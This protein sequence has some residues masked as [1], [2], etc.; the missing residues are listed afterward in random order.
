VNFRS[1]GARVALDATVRALVGLGSTMRLPVSSEALRYKLL[2]HKQGTLY[3]FAIDVS[4]S[5]A[6]NRIA[7]AKSTILKLLRR[8]YLNRDSVA[9]VSFHGTTANV[10]LPPSRSILRARRVLDSL[11]MGGSTPLGLGL[12]T[13]IELLELVGNKFGETVVLLFTDGHSNVP[14]RRGGLNLRAFRQVKIESELRELTVA[15]NRLTRVVVVDTQKEFESSEETRRLAKILNAGF[16][17][18][19]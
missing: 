17:K 10:D 9:I 4:G 1:A 3:V 19:G 14:L 8:S 6:A 5:M 15:L 11:R 18:V 16:V 13:T 2:K 12:V 7:R